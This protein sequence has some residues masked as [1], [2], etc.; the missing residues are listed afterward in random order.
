MLIYFKI[1]S[2]SITQAK[3]LNKWKADIKRDFLNTL[4]LEKSILVT[5]L[6]YHIPSKRCGFEEWMADHGH[7]APCLNDLTCSAS[8]RPRREMPQGVSVFH[9]NIGATQLPG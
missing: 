7:R 1:I 2:V 8:E 9:W 6:P 5:T 4:P 3:L